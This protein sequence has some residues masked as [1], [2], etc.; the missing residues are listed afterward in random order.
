M[1]IAKIL[2]YVPKDNPA[3]FNM[4]LEKY[5]QNMFDEVFH[6]YSMALL[7]TNGVEKYKNGVDPNDVE[8]LL[9]PEAERE[10][11]LKQIK[12]QLIAYEG[13]LTGVVIDPNDKD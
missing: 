10:A 2:S 3:Y 11:K 13:M 7:N 9:L 8:V 6:T 1:S 4:G 12:E 5:N